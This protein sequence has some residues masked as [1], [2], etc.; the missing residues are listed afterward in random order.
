MNGLRRVSFALAASAIVVAGAGAARGADADAAEAD[1][2]AHDF[3]IAF[4][5]TLTSDYLWRGITQ[6]DH[7]PALQGYVEPSFGIVYA[8]I[9][10][11]NVAFGGDSDVEVDLYAGIRPEFDVWSF[12]LG[13]THAFYLNDPGSDSGELFA[14]AYAAVAEPVTLGAEL[15]FNP[16]NSA[17]YV[18]ANTDITLPHN[19][20]VSGGI[21]AVNG[22]TS[23]ATWNVGLYYLIGEWGTLDLRYSGTSLSE[24]DCAGYTGLTGKECDG[25]LMASFSIDTSMSALK[26]E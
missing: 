14:K 26:G 2:V 20:G 17:T 23:Y 1:A 6:T 12:D 18:E 9:W 11:S 5:A 21:G 16:A 3:D 13:Y 15:Y 19:F 8:G 25:R 22:D 7:K 24:G 4:G 10:A